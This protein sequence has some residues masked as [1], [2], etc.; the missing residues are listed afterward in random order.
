ML[1]TEIFVEQIPD[2]Y[3]RFAQAIGE[4]HWKKRASALR[5]EIKGN[6][7]LERYI[8]DENSVAFQLDH[9][10]ELKEKYGAIPPEALANDDIFPAISLAAQ[11]LSIMEHSSTSQAR[12]LE[13]RVHGALKNTDDLRALQLELSAATHFIRRGYRVSWPELNGLGTFDLLVEDAGPSGL[14]IE[15]KSFSTDKGRKI[16]RRD[17]LEFHSILNSHLGSVKRGLKTGLSAVLTVPG[18]LPLRHIDRVALA[19]RVAAKILEGNSATVDDVYDIR[20]RKH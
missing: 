16:H 20:L 18:R 11:V 3:L 6:R 7:F 2:V 13:R 12:Q 14:E 19:K 10:R 8:R 15:C 4:S 9:L 17:A 5:Q 1:A